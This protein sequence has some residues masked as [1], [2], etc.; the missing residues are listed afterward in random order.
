MK[1]DICVHLNR[2]VFNEHPAFRLASDG[3]LRAL[4]MHFTMAHSAP[5]DLL[6]HTGESIDTLCFIVTGS[7]EVIQDDE[8][9]AIL[10]NTFAHLNELTH[11]SLFLLFVI[12]MLLL[13]LLLK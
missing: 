7:L 13:L 2:K 9:V 6:Y 1:A 10:G 8:V 11:L 3:C 5:G 12:I 4:A